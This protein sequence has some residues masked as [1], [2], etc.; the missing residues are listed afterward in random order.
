MIGLITWIDLDLVYVLENIVIVTYDSARFWTL[1]NMIYGT[2]IH[3]F[4]T[5]DDIIDMET[6]GLLDWTRLCE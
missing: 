4:K 3:S 2:S 5:G 6:A 1:E